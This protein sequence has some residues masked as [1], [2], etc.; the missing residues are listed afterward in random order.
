MSGMA[1]AGPLRLGERQSVADEPTPA[2]LAHVAIHD[3]VVEILSALPRDRLLDVPAGEGALAARL[4]EAGF[5]VHCCDL[6]PEIFRLKSIEIKQ[7][8]LLERLPYTDDEFQYLTCIEGLEHLENPAQAIREFRRLLQPGGHLIV[9]VPNI[10]NIEERLK[11]L[12]HGYT[13]HFKPLSKTYLERVR[14]D[15]EAREEIAL[16]VHAISYS[17]LRYHLESNGFQICRILRDKPKR[18]LWLYW[19]ALALIGLVKR[20][21]PRTKRDERWTDELNSAELLTG[22]NTLIVH[23]VKSE[24]SE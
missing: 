23:A 11:W 4:L 1:R 22:G 8:N 24:H 5:K 20:L 18:H 16:H 12:V 14:R 2:P 6:Y 21:T 19:P 7:G 3:R 10:H 15:H 17:E 13:S 9:S